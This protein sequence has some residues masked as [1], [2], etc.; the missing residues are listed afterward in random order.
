MKERKKKPAPPEPP[1]DPRLRDLLPRLESL[2]EELR[3]NTGDEA[4][5]THNLNLANWICDVLD[6]PED[7]AAIARVREAVTA[8]C[9]KYP[10]YG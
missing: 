7:E 4:R 10:V 3:D 2:P 1:S 8:Q 5:R 6:A 9:A